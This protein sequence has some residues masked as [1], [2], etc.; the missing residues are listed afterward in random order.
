MDDWPLAIDSPK[1]LGGK[2]GLI[3]VLINVISV[4]YPPPEGHMSQ[5]ADFPRNDGMSVADRLLGNSVGAIGWS[6]SSVVSFGTFVRQTERL[7]AL[8]PSSNLGFR[9]HRNSLS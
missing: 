8:L 6:S 4:R 2:P 9:A 3:T 5:Y 1:T 7:W